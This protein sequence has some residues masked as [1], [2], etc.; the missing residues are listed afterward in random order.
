MGGYLMVACPSCGAQRIWKAGFRYLPNGA[1]LQRFQCRKCGHR[2]SE[3]ISFD[4]KEQPRKKLHITLKNSP[5]LSDPAGKLAPSVRLHSLATEESKDKL[6]LSLAENSLVHDN[7]HILIHDAEYLN[8]WL[9]IDGSRDANMQSL[10]LKPLSSE[11][12]TKLLDFAWHLKKQGRADSTIQTYSSVLRRVLGMGANL[13]DPESIKEVLTSNEISNG[14]KAIIINAYT[15]FLKWNEATWQAPRY[16]YKPKIPFIPTEE[17]LDQLIAG[18]GQQT[19][20]L[21]QVLKETGARIGEALALNWTDINFKG[22]TISVNAPEKHG[23][24]RIISVSTKLLDMLNQLPRENER[25]F[26]EATCQTKSGNYWKQRRSLAKKLG[27]PRLMQITFH[28]FRH[29]KGSMEYHKTKDIM[30][31]K[32]LLGHRSIQSTM[33]YIT[34][35]S[36]LFQN[37]P[38]EYV[39]KVARNVTEAQQLVDVG[40]TYVCDFGNE[41]LF[42]KR[43]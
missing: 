21:L 2:F 40:F 39:S 18:V 14:V 16:D 26:G 25:V 27:N 7:S 24:A 38:D 20:A 11:L 35:E 10:K 1:R 32:Q 31:V 30:H 19:S 12:K 15:A 33:V 23:N 34:I 9:S 5:V 43:K 42:K 13:H 17:E 36:A 8:N 41:K 28:T 37:A 29:W 6:P 22:R 4:L 3:P